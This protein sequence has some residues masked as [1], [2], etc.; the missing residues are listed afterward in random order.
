VG[1]RLQNSN[2]VWRNK[3]NYQGKRLSI[4]PMAWTLIN[5]WQQTCSTTSC[6][7]PQS[8]LHSLH[9][10]LFRFSDLLVPGELVLV[11]VLQYVV[12]YID[13]VFWVRLMLWPV[14]GLSTR[15][16]TARLFAYL[17]RHFRIVNDVV[18]ILLSTVCIFNSYCN[19]Y[20]FSDISF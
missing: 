2:P 20:I 14:P 1:Y 7:Q 6:R 10:K 15:S 12:S 4:N 5:L 19:L 3:V 16:C 17:R 18:R 9:S 11:C 13:I 8:A